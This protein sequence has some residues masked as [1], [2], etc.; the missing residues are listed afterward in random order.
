M[1]YLIANYGSYFLKIIT[2]VLCG[3]LIGLE[4]E[5][6]RKPAGLKTNILICMGAT[7]Y[8][9]V[10]DL[11]AREAGMPR[12][13]D[14]GRIAAQ[15]VTGIGFIGAGCIMRSG[16]TIAGI[17]TASTIWIVAALGL[18]I[19]VGFP[20]LAIFFTVFVLLILVGVRKLEQTF[21]PRRRSH[22]KKVEE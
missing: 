5:M 17:T 16:P 1:D 15:V 8:M 11:V 14:P 13:A 6:S 9:I 3:G 20:L 4:R 2:A 7:I 12:G 18:V 22:E 10:S 21:R 19:G